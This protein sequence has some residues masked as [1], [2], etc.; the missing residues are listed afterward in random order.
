MLFY[1]FNRLLALGFELLT[2][3]FRVFSLTSWSITTQ[4]LLLH[5]LAYD[6]IPAH[7]IHYVY[8]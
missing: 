7:K 6:F 2:P 1:I 8:S 3:R 4:D 5:R